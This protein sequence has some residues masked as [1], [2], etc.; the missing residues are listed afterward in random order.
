VRHV[1]DVVVVGGGGY[2]LRVRRLLN[3]RINL[4]LTHYVDFVEIIA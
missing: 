3:Q 2:C 1:M 4:F